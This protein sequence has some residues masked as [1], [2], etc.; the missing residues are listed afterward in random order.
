VVEGNSVC[1]SPGRQCE[2]GCGWGGGGVRKEGRLEAMKEGREGRQ[3]GIKITSTSLHSPIILSAPCPLPVHHHSRPGLGSHRRKHHRLSPLE[4]RPGIMGALPRSLSISL[5]L[6]QFYLVRSQHGRGPLLDAPHGGFQSLGRDTHFFQLSWVVLYRAGSHFVS[7][8][9][10][11]SKCV[12]GREHTRL[13][14]MELRADAAQAYRVICFHG[15][16]SGW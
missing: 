6:A 5:A 4:I 8:R 2:S 15:S 14:Q 9:A 10:V 13:L 7:A 12:R 16:L 1:G 11:G 3:H